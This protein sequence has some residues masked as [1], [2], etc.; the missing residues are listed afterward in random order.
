MRYLENALG[1]LNHWWRFI[2]LF[3]ATVVGGVIFKVI[4]RKIVQ[5]FMIIPP[6]HEGIS[7]SL[8]LF[9]AI[10]PNVAC[11]ITLF[12]LFKPLHR[13]SYKELI[14][15]AKTMR[16]KRFLLSFILWLGLYAAY[17]LVDS[18]FNPTSYSINFNAYQF[19][20]LAI[21]SLMLFPFQASYEELV[22]R[23]YFAQGIGVLTRSRYWVIIIPSV[24]FALLHSFDPDVKEYGFSIMMGQYV[25]YGFIFGFITV[26]DD[27][28]EIAMGAHTATNFFV[29]AIVTSGTSIQTPSLFLQHSTNVY[30]DLV[31]L[32]FMGLIFICTFYKTFKWNYHVLNQ[33]IAS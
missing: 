31:A 9:L 24:I 26:L 10:V 8:D 5:L 18:L 16:W 4:V 14:S 23:G 15:G 21:I 11:I 27:G 30:K 33:R 6:N 13:R 20:V 32:V 19:F 7:S 25:V 3:L 17:L 2:V 28:L 22:M 1:G 12:L 29:S